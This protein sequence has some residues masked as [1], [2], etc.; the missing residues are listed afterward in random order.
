MMNICFICTGN[1]CRSPLA[2]GILKS[3]KIPGV[4]VRSAGVYATEGMPISNHSRFILEK[5]GMP[6][7]P[8]SRTFT[9]QDMEWADLVLTMTNAHKEILKRRFVNDASKIHTLNEYVSLSRYDIQDPY[10]GDLNSYQ[11]TFEELSERIDV[12][13]RKLMGE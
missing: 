3:K 11:Q 6:A 9:E 7:A 2:E 5:H 13:A 8:S 10:G 1:T 12:L 4:A